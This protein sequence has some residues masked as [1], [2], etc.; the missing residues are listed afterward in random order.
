[1][2]CDA[3]IKRKFSGVLFSAHNVLFMKGK[4]S[5]PLCGMSDEICFLLKKHRVKF[6]YVDV[7]SDPALHM[8]LRE[9]YPDN[10][11]P[12]LFVD[13]NFIG[14]YHKIYEMLTSSDINDIKMLF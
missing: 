1:M 3:Y 13:R 8:F 14:G 2:V 10:L 5:A 11:I 4:P 6:S 9:S 12:F 7:L